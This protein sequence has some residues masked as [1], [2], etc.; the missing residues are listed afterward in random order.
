MD[1]VN[2]PPNGSV[3][4]RLDFSDPSIV[5]TFL[6]HCHILSHEDQGMMAK[7]RVGTSPPL[8]TDKN[9]VSFAS[10]S[11]PPQTVNVSGGTAPYSVT[12]C[13]GVANATV[14]G[15]AIALAP[16]A[17][18]SC[19]LT[20]AD[21][22]SPSLTT[23]IS[24]NVAAGAPTMTLSPN[25]V[26]FADPTA[27]PLNV[28]IA[29]GA[30]PYAFA[31][32]AGIAS[33]SVTAQTLTVTP[34]TAGACSIV[35][36][37][38]NNAVASLAVSVN[39]S[40]VTSAQD[41]LTFHRDAARTGWYA[42]E[43]A[44]TTSNVN[45]AT[46]GLLRTLTAPSGVPAMNKVIAQP[47]FVSNQP[48]S[49]GTTHNLVLVAS[50]S[51]QIYA[52][53]DRTYAL[54]WHHDFTRPGVVPQPWT[55]SGCG[56]I[57]PTY[58][59]VGTPVIDRRLDRLYVVVAADDNG[60][61]AMRIHALSLVTGADAVAPSDVAQTIARVG[62]GTTSISPLNNM[63]RAALLEANGNVYVALG[64]HCDNA[65]ATTHGW[66]LSYD[67]SSLRMTG[68]A[69]E[70]NGV[71]ARNQYL[72]DA[73][74]S[75]FGPAADA[76]GNVYLA[77]GNGAYAGASNIAMSVIKLP[78]NLDLA[79]ASTFSP[80]SAQV[81][82]NYDLD[83][84][85]G[86][87]MLFP[88]QPGPFPHQLLQGGKCSY[89][90]AGGWPCWK[91]VLDRDA[92]GGHQSNNAGALGVQNIAG[93]MFGGPAYFRDATNQHVVYGGNPLIDFIAAP[94]AKGAIV[95]TPS[96]RSSVGCFICR[97]SGGSQPIVSSNGTVAG[98]AIVWAI[99]GNPPGG[100]PLSLYAFDAIKMGAPLFSANAGVWSV[101]GGASYVGSALTSPTVANG[102]V[103]VPVDGGVAV[104]GLLSKG[105]H[106]APPLQRISAAA[107]PSSVLARAAQHLKADHK[108]HHSPHTM[109]GTIASIN[110]ETFVLQ[111]RNGRSIEVDAS[112]A[113]ASDA[114]SAPL[115]VG[116]AVTVEGRRHGRLFYADD[117]V[118][119]ETLIELPPD[120]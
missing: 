63:N 86:G 5:G 10:S 118:R 55:D 2:V 11:A 38:A 33:G 36:T 7:I 73:W 54:V 92:L 16:V 51:G 50:T 94:N 1:N 72:G 71:V 6:F 45:A 89:N 19:L 21:A 47:L 64:S 106:A 115:F 39:A 61:P 35:V 109:Y 80:Q 69:A 91:Y 53:D 8:G 84:G 77:T 28:T 40:P 85:S 102:R 24:I 62:G 20:I 68:S 111:L 105:T 100:G 23:N 52:F 76:Q 81:D 46:F 9:G 22:S 67:A 43:A 49:G 90:A 12:G 95:L 83:L 65:S 30:A 58:G 87:V 79:A 31:G 29:G 32:C 114:Y 88:D 110:G 3:R 17:A 59:I 42:A 74:M 66:I 13:D 57:N 119:V 112:T 4:V 27:S 44:L 60:T 117:I 96:A 82:S 26:S 48:V 120:Q 113:I 37:A 41:N 75:G 107:V 78:G 97:D 99:K 15:S 14:N 70:T 34:R 101:A 56:D 98:T 93:A 103:Y 104:F 116:K 18:G 108:W 25:A